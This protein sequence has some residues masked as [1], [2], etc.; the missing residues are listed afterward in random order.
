M[1]TWIK[2]FVF[3]IKSIFQV[4]TRNISM[5]YIIKS[6]R[7]QYSLPFM[8]NEIIYVSRVFA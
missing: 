5:R 2:P 4:I 7:N 1:N 6:S 8:N 3:L